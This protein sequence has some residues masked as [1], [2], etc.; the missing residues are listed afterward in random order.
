MT[1]WP[2]LPYAEWR[3]TRDTL[4][5]YTQV[6][7]KLRLALSPFEPEWGHVPLYVTARG[8]TSSPLPVGLRTVDAELDLIDHLL[9]L[10]SSDGRVER[11]ALGG[12]VADFY[13]DVMG[14]LHSLG[15]DVTISTL[16]SEV[17][18][19]IPFPDDRVHDTYVPEQAGRFFRVLSMVTVVMNDHH[20]RFRGRTTPVEFFWGAFDLALSRFSGRPVSPP[21]GAGVIQRVGGDAEQICAGWWPGHAGHPSA[22]FYAYAYPRP[23]G[24]ET[25]AVLPSDGAWDDTAQEFLLEYDAVRAEADPRQ[26]IRQFLDSTY[27]GAATLLRWDS[28][29]T[30]V[31]APASAGG[32][33]QSSGGLPHGG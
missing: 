9:L 31:Q 7:G 23:D 15:V 6:I 13:G 24:I 3:P 30:R 28:D 14:A 27:A 11:R 2:A 29:L 21:P 32:L 10:R 20:A 18:D 26:S 16:P 12:S 4:H 17:D 22:A 19:A 5:M 33:T 1:D 8:L 25:T